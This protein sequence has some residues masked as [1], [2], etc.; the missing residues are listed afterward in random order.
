MA[1]SSAVARATATPKRPP[2]RPPWRRQGPTPPDLARAGLAS[3][4]HTLPSVFS[5]L[6]NLNL[7][8]GAIFT[9]SSLSSHKPREEEGD[10]HQQQR[11]HDDSPKPQH[12]AI[13]PSML[14]RLKSVSFYGYRSQELNTHFGKTLGNGD[15]SWVLIA[16][17]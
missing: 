14:Q 13:S 8:I 6:L 1:A 10:P 4:G 2:A 17:L 15:P 9:T 3:P 11:N 16:R 5:V 12:L 7:M